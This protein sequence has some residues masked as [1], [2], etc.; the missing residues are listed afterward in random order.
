MDDSWI[1]ASSNPANQTRVAYVKGKI[2]KVKSNNKFIGFANTND[3]TLD[4]H[5]TLLKCNSKKPVTMGSNNAELKPL[6]QQRS[7]SKKYLGSQSK[8]HGYRLSGASNSK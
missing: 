1:L 2:V 6:F 8:K 5:Q 7:K 4:G 3:P